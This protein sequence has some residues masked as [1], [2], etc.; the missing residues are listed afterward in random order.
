ML[1]PLRRLSRALPTARLTNR[2]SRPEPSSLSSARF[3]PE[4]PQGILHTAPHHVSRCHRHDRRRRRTLVLCVARTTLNIFFQIFRHKI[5]RRQSAG[6]PLVV[7]F[8]GKPRLRRFQYPS[9]PR[10]FLPIP[11]A[12]RPASKPHSAAS[13]SCHLATGHQRIARPQ[14]DRIYAFGVRATPRTNSTAVVISVGGVF[15][16]SSGRSIGVTAWATTSD[17]RLSPPS[18]P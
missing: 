5:Y 13:R 2:P 12:L 16:S 6:Q 14:A 18:P 3:S 8:N 1:P 11:P 4:V 10:V 15:A 7:S 17:S 9:R